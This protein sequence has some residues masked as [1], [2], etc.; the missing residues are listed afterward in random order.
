MF[1]LTQVML[2]METFYTVSM[3]QHTK[4]CPINRYNFY[5]FMYKLKINV[6]R[7]QKKALFFHYTN[8]ITGYK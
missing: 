2:L 6:N 1:S 7:K 5:I 4:W 8:N 3:H